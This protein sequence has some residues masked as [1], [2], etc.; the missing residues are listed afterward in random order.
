LAVE[1]GVVRAQAAQQLLP[2]AALQVQAQQR[3][4][5]I[6]SHA[7]AQAAELLAQAQA[8][9]DSL[10]RNAADE[11]EALKASVREEAERR[12]TVSWHERQWASAQALADKASAMNHRLA[13]VV[14][15]A[16]Q[17][18]VEVEG[19]GALFQRALAQIEELTFGFHG[20]K[21]RVHGADHEAAAKCVADILAKGRLPSL[22]LVIDPSLEAGSC[23]F[24][25]DAGILDAS[26]QTQLDALQAAMLRA[27]KRTT[28]DASAPQAN[29]HLDSEAVDAMAGPGLS[30]PSAG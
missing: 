6:V 12:A 19:R 25:S 24:E 17:R 18:I 10:R 16:V 28:A 15:R 14:T 23:V 2:L 13:E 26:L 1:H 21:L 22:S 27:I 5:D 29:A 9:A 11:I 20:S 7:Q 8:Q 30:T 4:E 3:A